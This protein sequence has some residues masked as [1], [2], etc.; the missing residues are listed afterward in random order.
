ML[1]VLAATRPGRHAT[2]GPGTA[3]TATGTAQGG[4]GSGA[5]CGARSGIPVLIAL[6]QLGEVLLVGLLQGYLTGFSN[7][8]NN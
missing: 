3:S 7:K 2:T 6:L 4:G 8:N 5:R 1:L